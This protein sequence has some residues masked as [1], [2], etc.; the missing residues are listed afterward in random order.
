M[1][2]RPGN[3]LAVQWLRLGALTAGA[4]GSIPAQGTKMPQATQRNQNQNKT[5]WITDLNAKAKKSKYKMSRRKEERKE[6]RKEGREEGRE[7][8]R[9]KENI[10][11]LGLGKNV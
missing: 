10:H 6:G 8:G 5:Q 9:E 2:H 11:H 7:G 4:P 3:S 1:Y